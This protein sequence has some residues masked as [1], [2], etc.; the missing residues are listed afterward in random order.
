MKNFILLIFCFLTGFAFAQTSLT[1]EQ[2]VKQ[3]V[4]VLTDITNEP[5]DQQSLVRFLVYAN[6]YDIEGIVATTSTHLRNQVRI[7]K[8]EELIQNYGKVKTNLDL[9]AKGFP[10]IEQLLS[11]TS[12]HLPLFSMEGVGEGKEDR[13]SVV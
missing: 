12:Q 1:F 4:F 7:D 8:I 3:R 11:V 10:S 5:D 13:K 2:P 9:H 6:E